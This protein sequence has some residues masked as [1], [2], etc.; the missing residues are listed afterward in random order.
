[1]PGPQNKQTSGGIFGSS[2]D[3]VCEENE[4]I[5]RTQRKT[6]ATELQE[7]NENRKLIREIKW[8]QSRLFGHVRKNE[9]ESFVTTINLN[10]KQL[11]KDKKVN[12][13]LLLTWGC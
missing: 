11:Q 8:T 12:N 13:R 7:A 1:M 3:A 5:P 10:G 4:N 6:N 9:L 2:R